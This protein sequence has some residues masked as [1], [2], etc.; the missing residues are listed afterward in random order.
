MLDECKQ[1]LQNLRDSCD[2]LVKCLQDASQAENLQE[3]RDGVECADEMTIIL[4]ADLF[5]LMLKAN[6]GINI[7]KVEV[8]PLK[9][10]IIESLP[11]EEV[12]EAA[13]AKIETVE[14]VPVK[15]EIVEVVSVK[16]EPVEVVKV[17][18]ETVAL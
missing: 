1:K 15:E 16:E 13:P 10:E 4:S 8:E 5:N 6:Q 11:K 14:V 17:E 18:P 9:S 3:F 2:K 7:E 12:V